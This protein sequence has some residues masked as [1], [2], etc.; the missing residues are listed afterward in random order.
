MRP[1]IV[2]L[3]ALALL[4]GAGCP[5]S[6]DDDP[7]SPYPNVTVSGSVVDVRGGGVASAH[8]MIANSYDSASTDTDGDGRF[9]MIVDGADAPSSI[10][11]RHPG[12]RPRDG[13]VAVA[14][15]TADAGVWATVSNQE[16]LFSTYGGGDDLYLVRADGVGGLVR[17]TDTPAVRETTPRRS[18]SG[19]VVRWADT[20]GGAVEEAAWDGSSP[21]VVYTA[22]GG[23]EVTGI[24]WGERGTFVARHAIGPDT[25]DVVIAED[26]P[27]TTFNY[28]W[29]GQYPDLSPATFGF[30]GPQPIQGNMLAF[31]GTHA[32][33]A[34]I[35]TAFPYFTDTFLV[36]TWLAGSAAGD[37]YPRWSSH[38]ANGSLD[39]AFTRGYGLY[40]SHVTSDS[41]QNHYSTP[42]RVY[43]AGAD[44]VNANQ[45]AWS[46]SVAGQ[47]DHLAIAVNV[48]SSGSTLA[49]RGDLVLL[50]YDLATGAVVGAPRVV[51]DASVAGH[52]LALA[53]DWR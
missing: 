27:G 26:P 5:G 3:L 40:V 10:S 44:D 20:T 45:F 7:V 19:L 4:G 14:G 29:A 21:R 51:Y 24:A 18:A 42:V 37:Y 12:Q 39:L 25:V 8:V 43:G 32:S 31:A 17:L 47:L 33:D 11:I 16:I 1:T 28:A 49:E 30:V 48:V 36:P 13:A 2:I 38:R 50:D 23:F 6:D 35:F 46:P 9:T 34:G 41:Q 53:V 22:P 52:G 15:T